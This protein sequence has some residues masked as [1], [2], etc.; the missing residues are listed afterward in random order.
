MAN[1]RSTNR[2][3]Y[4]NEGMEEQYEGGR[5]G[6]RREEREYRETEESH[7]RDND[8]DTDKLATKIVQNELKRRVAVGILIHPFSSL[9]C[10]FFRLY[11]VNQKYGQLQVLIVH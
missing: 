10:F 4:R 7:R 11:K 1:R 8:M 3:I 2:L 6:N 5:L 9:F